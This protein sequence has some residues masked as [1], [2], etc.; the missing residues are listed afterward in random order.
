MSTTETPANSGDI[1]LKPVTAAPSPRAAAPRLVEKF[2][3]LPR[4]WTLPPEP[5]WGRYIAAALLLAILV[6]Y[7]FVMHAYYAGAHGGV[8]QSGYLRT[9]QLLVDT[10]RLSFI[11][12]DPYQFASRMC[13]M[14]E[15]FRDLT[16]EEVQ[17]GAAPYHI[18]A[19]YPFGF[20]L[21]AA[22]ARWA[23]GSFAAMYMVN[24]ASTVL[25]LAFAYLMFR[26][27][28]TRFTSLI[29][30]LLLACNPLTLYYSNDAN[31]HATTLLFICIGFWGLLAWM[32]THSKWQG[33][34][35]GFALGYACT[36]RYSEFLLVLPVASA[37]AA[38]FFANFWSWFKNRRTG[39][40]GMKL[41]PMTNW[42]YPV[43]GW[44]IPIATLCIICW[45]SF[46]QPWKTG[47]T[48]C[49]EDT[50]FGWKYFLGASGSGGGVDTAKQG[51]WETFL[52]Q[53]NRTGLYVLWPLALVGLFGMVA[54]LPRV[55]MVLL[56]WLLPP[57][58]LYMFYYWA[59]NGA[60]TM[61]NYLRF[62]ISI[63]PGLIS[64]ASGSPSTPSPTSRS[65]P[66]PTPPRTPSPIT[67][68]PSSPSPLSPW[69]S[70]WSPPGSPSTTP[71]NTS[72]NSISSSTFSPP[73]A[74]P[75]GSSGIPA[76]ACSSPPS[77]PSS[78]P[79]PG[80]SNAAPPPTKPAWPWVWPS[81]PCS[82]AASTSTPSPPSSNPPTPAG[83]SSAR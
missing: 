30:V 79:A 29:G 4:P 82:P 59:P 5:R 50:G 9:A 64:P 75:S 34:V 81:P 53:L 28:L 35:G 63:V 71:K 55:A 39:G 23:S 40:G 54:K 21:L 57:T 62:F 20:P 1:P 7:S 51:N 78:S 49:H 38:S 80:V 43:L 42:L 66:P 41:A 52:L 48:Y 72:P 67:S 61:V 22:V 68:P 74:A 8:D 24:P 27:L 36:I 58:F 60:E 37:A 10:H 6:L 47:Y 44:A 46:G 33:F 17:A 32:R 76:W 31:S 18:Y 70:S 26:Q 19:K 15:P 65:R 69:P 13:I 83:S 16:P 11:P 56:L 25:A 77:S 14:T 73:P 45:I 2:P 12:V 3:L